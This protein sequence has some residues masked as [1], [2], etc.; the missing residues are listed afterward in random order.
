[1]SQQQTHQEIESAN[2]NFEPKQGAAV[3]TEGADREEKS[4]FFEKYC[5][6][7]PGSSQCRIYDL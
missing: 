2:H 7:N 5:E 3:D 4:S 1:M 6:A